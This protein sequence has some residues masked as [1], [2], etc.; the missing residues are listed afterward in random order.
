MYSL[1]AKEV[2]TIIK[3]NLESIRF[4]HFGGVVNML[5]SVRVN[6]S[7]LK[8][9]EVYKSILEQIRSNFVKRLKPDRA[10]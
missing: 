1:K 8:Q 9:A 3:L 5:D 6:W 10:D 4:Q 7:M 2:K